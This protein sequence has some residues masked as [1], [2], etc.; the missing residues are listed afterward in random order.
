MEKEDILYVYLKDKP[1]M[2]SKD[3]KDRYGDINV[4]DLRLRII[5]YQIEHYGEQVSDRSYLEKQNFD[6]HHKSKRRSK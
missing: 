4:S 1:L 2:S 5:N 6:G 3:L